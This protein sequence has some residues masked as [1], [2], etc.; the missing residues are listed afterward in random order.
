[1]SSTLDGSQEAVEP[2]EDKNQRLKGKW[3]A[4]PKPNHYP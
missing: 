4:S 2:E 3:P 1:M